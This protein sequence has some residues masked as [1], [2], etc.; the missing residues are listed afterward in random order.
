MKLAVIGIGLMGGSAALAMKRAG[1]VDSV[2][3]CDVNEA[4]VARAIGLG[5]AEEGGTDPAAAARGADVVMVATPVMTMESIF[6][7]VAPEL[8]PGAVITDLGSV[9]GVVQEAAKRSLGDKIRQYAPCHPIA[10][11]EKTGVENANPDM[12]VGKRVISTAEPGMAPEAVERMEVLW[13]STG[14]RI[15]RMTPARHDEVFGLMSHLPHVL[16]Y[17]LVAMITES[18]D[19]DTLLSMGGTGFLD[20]SRIAASS[21]VMWRDICLANRQAISVGLRRYREELER[22]QKAID[23]GNADTLVAAFARASQA[24]RKLGQGARLRTPEKKA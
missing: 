9:R 8:A 2:Y 1:T 24:R 4:S 16:A 10:G 5:V 11:G 17:A 21:P 12:F 20:F 7:A 19:P 18:R 23:E 3:A 15:L 22:F 14:A 13:A 6:R